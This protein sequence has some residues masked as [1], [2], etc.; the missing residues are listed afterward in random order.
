MSNL[1]ILFDKLSAHDW[2]YQMSDDHRVWKRGEADWTSLNIM[3]DAIIGGKEL[4]NAFKT[5]YYTGQPWGNEQQP[6]PPRPP[7]KYACFDES[8]DEYVPIGTFDTDGDAYIAAAEHG[9]NQ[10]LGFEYYVSPCNQRL[11][12]IDK[13]LIIEPAEEQ[14]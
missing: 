11:S 5:H 2:Y 7:A 10:E 14:S 9:L 1:N 6:L 3:A 13:F 4:L 8:N 12:T